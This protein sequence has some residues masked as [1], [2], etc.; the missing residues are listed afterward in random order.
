MSI[1]TSF[2]TTGRAKYHDLAEEIEPGKNV[3]QVLRLIEER[4]PKSFED[5]LK[6]TREQME[7]SRKFV[8]EKKQGEA[9]LL[10]RHL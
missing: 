8:I 6:A 9:M 1:C 7:A 2:M 10:K 3:E 4:A 5:A